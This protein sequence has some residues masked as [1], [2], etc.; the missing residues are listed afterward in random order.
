MSSDN[1]KTFQMNVSVISLSE[2]LWMLKSVI[3]LV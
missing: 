2:C 1:F 3:A